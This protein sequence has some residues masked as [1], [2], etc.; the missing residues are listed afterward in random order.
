[1][2]NAAILKDIF[3]VLL[4][5]GFCLFSLCGTLDMTPFGINMDSDLQNYAQILVASDH[6][7]DFPT[8]PI[9]PLLSK[10]PGVPNLLTMLAAWLHPTDNVATNLLCTGAFA[11]FLHYIAYYLLGRWLFISTSLSAL[12][13]F[14]MSLTVYWAYGTFWGIL[15]S[16]PVPRYFFAIILPLLTGFSCIAVRRV[17][18]RPL[19]MFT[20]GMCMFIHTVSTLMFGPMLFFSFFFLRVGRI[21][22][23]HLGLTLLNGVCFSLPVIMYLWWLLSGENAIPQETALFAQLRAYRFAEDFGRLW[24]PFRDTFLLYC[25]APPILPT[26]II[27]AYLLWR[28]RHALTSRQR[29]FLSL[30]PGLVFGM[31]VM[32]LVCTAEIA[33]S[34]ALGKNNMSQEIL[35]GTRFLVPLSWFMVFF[36]LSLFWSRVHKVLKACILAA[37]VFCL[38]VFAQDK[39]ILAF[40]HGLARVTHCQRL[41]TTAAE[42][43]VRQSTL[44]REAL[45]ALKRNA[46]K[47]ELVFNNGN[48]MSVRYAAHCNML[49]IHKDGNIIYYAHNEELAR[50]WLSMQEKINKGPDGWIEAWKD[51]AASLLLTDR[52]AS[53]RELEQ[54]AE[55][56]YVNEKWLLFRRR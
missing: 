55:L 33:L 8:D 10:D 36:A 14:V 35:R 38:L 42:M 51:S 50:L 21:I 29:D 43:M 28:Q 23:S 11:I 6:P 45:D 20:A 25:Y 31:V 39:Q 46:R 37:S 32:C 49:P 53:R 56:L 16:D 44:Q 18:L 15:H 17:W 19:V 30:F 5:G 48:L 3:F 34:T 47:G 52:T 4:V 13:S 12:L 22:R 41:D 40:R 54:S 1:M 27:C 24:L 2:K 7:E 26:G 9:V